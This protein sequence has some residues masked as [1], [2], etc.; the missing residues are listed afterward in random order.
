MLKIKNLKIF[1]FVGILTKKKWKKF[2]ERA[3]IIV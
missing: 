1:F 3:D 2:F